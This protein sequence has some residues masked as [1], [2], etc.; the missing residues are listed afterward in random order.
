[1]FISKK[2]FTLPLWIL[3][4]LNITKRASLWKT[5]KSWT[6]FWKFK[7]IESIKISVTKYHK[8]YFQEFTSRKKY[9]EHFPSSYCIWTQKFL[10]E[11]GW[12]ILFSTY[13]NEKDFVINLLENNHLLL[14][15]WNNFSAIPLQQS[16]YPRDNSSHLILF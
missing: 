6:I 1:M 14:K 12:L 13:N 8:K 10:R 2:F 7:I 5:I 4:H 16:Y 9:T 11:S 15:L 3:Q